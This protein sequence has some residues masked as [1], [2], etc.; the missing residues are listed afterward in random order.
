[1]PW[2]GGS[3]HLAHLNHG[4]SLAQEQG[5]PALLYEQE[6]VEGAA[7]VPLRLGEPVERLSNTFPG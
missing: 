3:Q 2:E 4:A 6:V 1:M 7:N 5:Q